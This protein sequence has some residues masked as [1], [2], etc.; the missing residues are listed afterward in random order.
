MMKCYLNK[1]IS[2]VKIFSRYL[3]DRAK[4]GEDSDKVTNETKN[5]DTR[6]GIVFNPP[7][8]Q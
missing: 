8:M 6:N 3:G 7:E 4:N 5:G 2:L 1:T